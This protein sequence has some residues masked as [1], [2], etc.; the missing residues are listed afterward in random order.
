MNKKNQSIYWYIIRG[1]EISKDLRK[2][3][4]S[5]YK[6]FIAVSSDQ[7]LRVEHTKNKQEAIHRIYDQ[8]SHEKFEFNK[9]LLKEVEEYTFFKIKESFQETPT[10]LY[11]VI[12]EVTYLPIS[13]EE[14]EHLISIIELNIF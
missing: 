9:T 6:L 13:R 14:Q 4:I 2:N 1:N 11:W 3:I 5:P 8:Y 7:H 12:K 10:Y